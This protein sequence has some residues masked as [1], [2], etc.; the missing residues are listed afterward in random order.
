M[1]PSVI[2]V[3]KFLDAVHQGLLI[4][5]LVQDGHHPYRIAKK[6][7]FIQHLA[8]R[9]CTAGDI[10]GQAEKLDS[11]ARIPIGNCEVTVDI[12]CDGA[13]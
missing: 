3:Q 2:A 9:K 6:E 10:P 7:S 5:G 13:V 8:T 12:L 4:V 11:I 1:Q